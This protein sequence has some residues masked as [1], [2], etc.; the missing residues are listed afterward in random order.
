MEAPSKLAFACKQTFF[1]FK[2]EDQVQLHDHI[3]E[4][5]WAGGGRWD[6]DTIYN[7]PIQIRNYWVRKINAMNDAVPTPRK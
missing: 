1:G 2:P 5:I 3:F 4:L 6:W 7:L